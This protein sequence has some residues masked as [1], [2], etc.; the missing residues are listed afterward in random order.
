MTQSQRPKLPNLLVAGAPKCGTTS[1]HHY[2]AQHPEIF[3]SPIKEPS[4]FA[5]ADFLANDWYRERI[6]RDRPTLRAFLDGPRTKAIARVVTE[7]DDYASL[8]RDVRSETA[9][10][11]SSVSYFAVPG[12]A[13]AIRSEIPD[14]RLIFIL[15]D[16]TERLWSRYVR[17]IEQEP[18]TTF[19]AW[20]EGRRHME[21]SWL[22]VDNAKYATHLARFFALFPADR[23]RVHLYED[24][25]RDP[26]STLR[27]IFEFLD[28]DARYTADVSTR[29]NPSLPMRFPRL[30]RLRRKLMGDVSLTRWL[31]AGLAGALHRAYRKDRAEFRPT[32]EDRRMV[33]DLYGDEIEATAKLLGKDL[34]AWLR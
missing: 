19:R 26:A 27:A 21:P 12:A 2:L 22:P 4:Y 17:V 8:F 32:S 5:R 30:H 7:W 20:M 24:F 10:G 33:I 18:D 29:H 31:P 9:I 28:V 16:P 25:A 15:R 23:I 13:A 34:S 11:E 1:L 6:E 14:A 3:M